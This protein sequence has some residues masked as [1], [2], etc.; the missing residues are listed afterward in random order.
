MIT[1]LDVGEVSLLEQRPQ[2]VNLLLLVRFGTHVGQTAIGQVVLQGLKGFQFGMGR[3]E[4]GEGQ[5][6]DVNFFASS[7]KFRNHVLR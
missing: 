5:G 7:A 1:L 2:V 3:M 6:G 4:L